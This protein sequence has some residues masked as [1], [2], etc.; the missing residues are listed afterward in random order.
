MGQ[1]YAEQNVE[2]LEMDGR[3]VLYGL[4]SGAEAGV[5]RFLGKVL[6]KRLT[7]AGSTLRS[8]SKPY[9]ALHSIA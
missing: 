6:A 5:G 3:W 8:R 2:V 7:L 9:K 4:M 1:D